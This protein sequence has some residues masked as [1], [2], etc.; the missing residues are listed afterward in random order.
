MAAINE[1]ISN[2][3]DKSFTDSPLGKM[4]KL[5]DNEVLFE[6]SKREINVT[7]PPQVFQIKSKKP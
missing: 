1:S 6:E 5:A 4:Y 3:Q 2:T 7:A